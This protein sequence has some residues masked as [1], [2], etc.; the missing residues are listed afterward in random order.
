MTMIRMYDDKDYGEDEIKAVSPELYEYRLHHET[1]EETLTKD[2]I[3][4]KPLR[5][6]GFVL[7]LFSPLIVILWFVAA[8]LDEIFL[9]AIWVYFCW[10]WVLTLLFYG[11]GMI[12]QTFVLW[13]FPRT[14]RIADGIVSVCLPGSR[15]DFA[16]SGLNCRRATSTY[17]DR[18]LPFCRFIPCYLIDI[19]SGT[20]IAVGLKPEMYPVFDGFFRLTDKQNNNEPDAQDKS[21]SSADAVHPAGSFKKL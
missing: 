2:D 9:G 16:L 13:H 6:I 15:R 5:W 1:L 3:R 18:Y 11:C 19:S 20:K 21:G 14:I 12:N 4:W 7:L 8:I 10:A 17:W